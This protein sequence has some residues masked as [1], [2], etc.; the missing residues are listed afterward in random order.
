VL[1]L[2][3]RL[4]DLPMA[5]ALSANHLAALLLPPTLR[6]LYIAA[7]NDQAGLM[8][9]ARLTERAGQARIEAHPLL[10]CFDDWNAE[11]LTLGF[12]KCFRTAAG[13]LSPRRRRTLYSS[14]WQSGVSSRYQAR[15]KCLGKLT[16]SLRRRK[17]QARAKT[18]HEQ[19]STSRRSEREPKTSDVLAHFGGLMLRAP[20]QRGS[21]PA[22]ARAC[23]LGGWSTELH[24]A[25]SEKC[26]STHHR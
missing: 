15:V 23:R 4:P 13:Q 14:N 18:C 26:G 12:A 3:S 9:L 19:R 8:T 11:L 17:L 22:T 21:S 16:E 20:H 7:D 25:A 6:R 10:P 24:V 5:A 1:A 2:S